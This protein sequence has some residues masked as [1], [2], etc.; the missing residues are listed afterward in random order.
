M[1]HLQ[2]CSII[3]FFNFQFPRVPRP[4]SRSLE[5]PMGSPNSFGILSGRWPSSEFPPA[6]RVKF[7]KNFLLDILSFESLLKTIPQIVTSFYNYV[8]K[9]SNSQKNHYCLTPALNLISNMF[10]FSFVRNFR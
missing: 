9:N 1:N 2:Y 5:H 7:D 6:R 4:A 3:S 10:S 8:W